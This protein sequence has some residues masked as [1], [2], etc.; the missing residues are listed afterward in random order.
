MS[1]VE[2]GLHD[3]GGVGGGGNVS[4][5]SM[6]NLDSV[7]KWTPD[8]VQLWIKVP[9]MV[10]VAVAVLVVLVVMNRSL[11]PPSCSRNARG[12][13]CGCWHHLKSTSSNCY[14]RQQQQ[15]HRYCRRLSMLTSWN[16]LE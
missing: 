4:K 16:E 8:R 2:F 12:A 14:Y 10:A 1:Q 11:I 13:V 6:G 9:V 7:A 15:H 5:C 3:L